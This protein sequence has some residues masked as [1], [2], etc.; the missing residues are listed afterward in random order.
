[1]FA[2]GYVARGPNAG[3]LVRAALPHLPGRDKAAVSKVHPGPYPKPLGP[4]P[5]F[6]LHQSAPAGAAA[7]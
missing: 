7:D 6:T 2:E 5:T 3:T 4:G 1:M